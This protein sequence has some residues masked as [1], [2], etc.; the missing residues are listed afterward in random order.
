MIEIDITGGKVMVDDEFGWLMQFKWHTTGGGYA[1]HFVNQKDSEFWGQPA[2]T[3]IHM[4]RVIAGLTRDDKRVVDHVNH[5]KLDN[6][7]DNLRICSAAE[8][9]RNQTSKKRYK[10][11]FLLA[12]KRKKKWQSIIIFNRERHY[13]G[14]FATQEEAAMAYNAAAVKF[15][16]E[17]ACLNIIDEKDAT[18]AEVA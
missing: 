4:H 14:T 12:G 5:D 7:R 1:V 17:F 13:L 10:G 6:R 16:G 2:K 9:L 15:F 18:L 8:N 11:V 3:A